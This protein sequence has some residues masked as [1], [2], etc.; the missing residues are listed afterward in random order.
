MNSAVE[1]TVL[2]SC[3]AMSL[4]LYGGPRTRA[5][6][7]RW[8]LEEKGIAYELKGAGPSGTSTDSPITW[9]SI[10]SENSRL[11]WIPPCR[12]WTVNR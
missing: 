8:Y 4:I 3:M 11:W 12:D 10:P 9:R 2:N 5:S 6:M 7:P 1:E